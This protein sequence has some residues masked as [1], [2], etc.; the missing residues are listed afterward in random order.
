MDAESENLDQRNARIQAEQG[1]AI[2]RQYEKFPDPTN[3]ERQLLREY[4][5]FIVLDINEIKKKSLKDLIVW[6]WGNKEDSPERLLG[7][8]LFQYRLVKPQIWIAIAALIITTLASLFSIY[9]ELSK[10][11][12]AAGKNKEMSVNNDRNA[13]TQNQSR[14][15]IPSPSVNIIPTVFFPSFDKSDSQTIKPIKE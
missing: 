6:I 12:L 4:K 7:G 3:E 9:L 5:E 13:N 2:I 11:N 14:P 15:K 8:Y 10:D 1:A